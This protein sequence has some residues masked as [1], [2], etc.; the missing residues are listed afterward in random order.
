MRT[1]ERRDCSWDHTAW[2][3]GRGGSSS[4]VFPP[5]PS[6]QFTKEDEEEDRIKL[7]EFITAIEFVVWGIT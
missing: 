4:R 1:W 5:P 3:E 6:S 7:D 2:G